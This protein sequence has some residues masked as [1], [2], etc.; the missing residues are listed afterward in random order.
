MSLNNHGGT[1]FSLAELEGLPS[2]EC[3]AIL[4]A[5]IARNTERQRTT[6]Q[7][8]QEAES[9]LRERMQRRGATLADCGEYEAKLEQSY[10]YGYDGEKLAEL[11][12]HLD[13]DTYER[14]VQWVQP[15][16]YL[17]VDKRELNKLAKLGG[18]VKE[19]IDAAVTGMPSPPRLV[20]K[21]KA[22]RP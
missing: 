8:L 17:K 3:D 16:P 21:R 11:Q 19:I 9:L 22:V 2:Y 7:E 18:P 13:V 5:T 6:Q 15:A 20:L 4:A 14:A 1:G 10:S 12:A